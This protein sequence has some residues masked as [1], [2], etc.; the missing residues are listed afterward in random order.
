VTRQAFPIGARRRAQEVLGELELS[1]APIDPE[2]I[3]KQR[4][5][6]I[7]ADDRFP[8]DCFGALVRAGNHFFIM[9]SSA[10]FTAGHRRFTIAHELGHFHLDG[11]IDALVPGQAP[12]LSFGAN[13]T[14]R[15]DPFE[16]EADAFASEL[17]M[18]TAL[19][20]A[21]IDGQAPGLGAVRALANTFIVSM[22]AAA[23]R[24]A[25]LS[26]EPVAVL[27]SRDRVL[28]WVSF[29]PA[30]DGHGWARQRV[31]GEWAPRWS[32][33]VRLATERS[34]VLA[35]EEAS[36]TGLLSEWFD[37]APHAEVAEEALGLGGF[38]RVLTVLTCPGLP[39]AAEE[40][41]REAASVPR[42]WRDALRTYRLE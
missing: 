34:R 14:N 42:D 16:V 23:V 4:E 19:A 7:H 32:A 13:F 39:D 18:P 6:E 30:F 3:A 36:A 29:A 33:T 27:L 37:G 8:T 24:L 20:K 38:G 31:R 25:T 28:E 11:H 9:V 17:L 1:S 22:S 40:E 35:A 26:G 2:W 12:A 10:C 21:V 41:E 15:K 5:I